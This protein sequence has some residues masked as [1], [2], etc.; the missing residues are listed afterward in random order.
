MQFST[1]LRL[2][3]IVRLHNKFM[4]YPPELL[5][6]QLF[7]ASASVLLVVV[8]VFAIV[9]GDRTDAD[10]ANGL[11]ALGAFFVLVG[12][13]MTYLTTAWYRR[14]ANLVAAG[15]KTPATMKLIV[16]RDFD[17]TSLYAEVALE[18]AIKYESARVAVLVPTWE[19]QSTVGMVSPVMVYIESSSALIKAVSTSRGMLWCIPHNVPLKQLGAV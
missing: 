19:Y 16:E 17:S 4:P 18:G 13:P 8:G 1:A 15:Q 6:H 5:R 3:K 2:I 12:I 14:A 10:F 7:A 11:M 9:Q